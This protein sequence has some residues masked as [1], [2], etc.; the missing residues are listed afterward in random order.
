MKSDFPNSDDWKVAG[1]G[2]IVAVICITLVVYFA[3]RY[4]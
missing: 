3:L 4:A 2:F 1:E